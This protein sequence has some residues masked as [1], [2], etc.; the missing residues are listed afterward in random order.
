MTRSTLL[1]ALVPALALALLAPAALA[2]KPG[3]RAYDTWK[4]SLVRHA[5]ATNFSQAFGSE[6]RP[7]AANRFDGALIPFS[8]TDG[9]WTAIPPNDD[10]FSGIVPLGFDFDFYGDTYTEGC[11]NNNGNIS[12]EECFSTFTPTGFPSTQY[13]MVAGFWSD[14]DTRGPGSGLAWYKQTTY[15]GTPVFAVTYDSTGYFDSHVDKRVTFQIVIADTPTLPGGNNVCFDYGNMDFTTGDASFGVNGFGGAPATVG[16][17]KGDGVSFFQYGRYDKPGTDYD[18]PTGET[19]GVD[20]LDGQRICVNTGASATNIPPVI[21]SAPSTTIP[22]T[23]GMPVSFTVQFIAPESDQ[24]TTLTTGALPAWFSCTLSNGA[25]GGTAT[26][27]CSGTPPANGSTP[28]TITATDNGTPVLSTTFSATIVATGGGGPTDTTAP[29]CGA[30][31]FDLTGNGSVVSSASD[32]E[33]GIASVT[34][35]TLRNLE[36]FVS[37]A[38]PFGV[39]TSYVVPGTP[40]SVELR[41]TRIDPVERQA[42]IIATVTNGAGLSATCD[43]VVAELDASADATAL[44][45]PSPNPMRGS[46]RVPF[47]LAEAGAVRLRVF[48]SVGREVARLVDAPMDAGH[49]AVT[50]DGNDTVGRALASGVYVV[51]LEASGRTQT[52]MLTVV[53]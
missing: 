39:G 15:N 33:S 45:A 13:K 36:G 40:G 4:M 9:T 49:Y 52:R 43:P 14:I 25:P 17:N 42:A 31:S 1:R 8:A 20:G 7:D 32:P 16:T 27:M 28:V 48:D 41:G 37:G 53:R 47:S 12:F 24:A 23:V 11:V 44:L 50:W 30:I 38:G 10:G 18:G 5:P 19:D 35:T 21:S 6:A 46:A 3:T 26:A 51:R 22:A 2:Q 29:V 34:F